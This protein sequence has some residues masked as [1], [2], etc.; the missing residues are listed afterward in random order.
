MTGEMFKISCRFILK[1]GYICLHFCT[2]NH[3]QENYLHNFLCQTNKNLSW[4]QL[5]F[6]TLF[7]IVFALESIFRI[8]IIFTI[9]FIWPIITVYV[10]ITSSILENKGNGG[11]VLSKVGDKVLEQNHSDSLLLKLHILLQM[12]KSTAIFRKVWSLTSFLH[13]PWL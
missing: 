5:S 10:T 2:W 12:A 13:M 3:S 7:S 1:L 4:Y 6:N 9:V 11:L 8:C